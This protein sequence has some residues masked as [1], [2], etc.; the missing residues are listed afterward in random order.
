MDTYE[1]G[2]DVIPGRH[3][4]FQNGRPECLLPGISQ[5]ILM[6]KARYVAPIYFVIY[7]FIENS[8]QIITDMVSSRHL[9]FNK[10]ATV[11]ITKL[12]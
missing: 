1:I 2:T 4:E 7:S 3:L 5:N 6:T 8:V 10:M 11:E 9:E 12:A